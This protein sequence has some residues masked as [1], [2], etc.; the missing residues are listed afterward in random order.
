MNPFLPIQVTSFYWNIISGITH[1]S[2]SS[3]ASWHTLTHSHTLTHTLT[4]SEATWVEAIQQKA[5]CVLKQWHQREVLCTEKTRF[6]E[7][8]KS[9][10]FFDSIIYSDITCLKRRPSWAKR[11]SRMN[12]L[13]SLW[14]GMQRTMWLLNKKIT[15]LEIPK[16]HGK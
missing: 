2:P 1:F 16:R 12:F 11:S 13:E 7:I 15:L 14:H 5:T 9:G 8:A 10:P 3:S 4:Q 6:R